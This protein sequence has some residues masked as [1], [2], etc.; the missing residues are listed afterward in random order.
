MPELLD[1]FKAFGSG[2]R[3]ILGLALRIYGFIRA[4]DLGL[5]FHLI[6]FYDLGFHQGLHLGLRFQGSGT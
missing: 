2:T 3:F 4:Y 1:G 5:R 6:R